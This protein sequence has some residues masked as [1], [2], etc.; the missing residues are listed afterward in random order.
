MRDESD[1][2]LERLFHAARQERAD[3][4]GVEEYF[5][6]RLMARIREQQEQRAPWYLL[7]WRCV[8]ACAVAAALLAVLSL[9]L[10]RSG[11]GD[12][13]AAISSGQDEYL[14]KSFMAGE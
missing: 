10:E 6:V 2:R 14:A 1:L 8:P 7:A 3:T 5:E 12:L 9:S 11:S 13:F 4:S